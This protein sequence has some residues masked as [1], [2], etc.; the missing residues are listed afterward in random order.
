MGTLPRRVLW[1]GGRTRGPCLNPQS[2]QLCNYSSKST[3]SPRSRTVSMQADLPVAL[4]RCSWENMAAR[5]VGRGPGD[6][7]A[8]GSP[9]ALTWRQPHS[10]VGQEECRQVSSRESRNQGPARLR[11]VGLSPV[12][13]LH[14]LGCH[15]CTGG[16]GLDSWSEH[17]PRLQVS[18]PSQGTRCQRQPMGVSL[19]SL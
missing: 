17:R 5:E 2:P 19:L 11:L 18:V 1:E 8:P 14:W 7:G 6:A 4:G 3:G 10:Q 13:T 9:A 12:V 16:D 15:R